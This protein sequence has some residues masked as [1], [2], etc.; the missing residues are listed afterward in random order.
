MNDGEQ[1]E[2]ERWVDFLLSR[3]SKSGSDWGKIQGGSGK[4]NTILV[5]HDTRNISD[6][7]IQR[8]SKALLYL[9]SQEFWENMEVP[10]Q[11]NNFLKNWKIWRKIA[12]YHIFTV[13]ALLNFER[14]PLHFLV[15]FLPTLRNRTFLECE[16]IQ[17]HYC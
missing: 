14:I 3:T 16:K 12:F 7:E 2:K 5:L 11:P 6:D 13:I 8:L 10:H 9:V 1:L 4:M 17:W 15:I